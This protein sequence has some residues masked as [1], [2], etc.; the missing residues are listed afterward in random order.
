MG[1]RPHIAST[2]HLSFQSSDSSPP[3]A[4]KLLFMV[5]RRLQSKMFSTSADKYSKF[6]MYKNMFR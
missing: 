5:T 3:T 4:Q 2:V 1:H 6:G